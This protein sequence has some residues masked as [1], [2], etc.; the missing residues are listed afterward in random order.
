[1]NDGNIFFYS[2]KSEW[3]DFYSNKHFLFSEFNLKSVHMYLYIHIYTICVYIFIQ[4]IYTDR[5][6]HST[7]T[8]SVTVKQVNHLEL[9]IYFLLQYFSIYLIKIHLMK[10]TYLTKIIVTQYLIRNRQML[11]QAYNSSHLSFVHLL[12]KGIKKCTS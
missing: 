3:F 1:M 7:Y 4:Y 11:Q 6:T 8:Y 12:V 9:I 2:L 5:Q 10:M